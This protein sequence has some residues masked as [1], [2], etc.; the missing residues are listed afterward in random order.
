MQLCFIVSHNCVSYSRFVSQFSE[1]IFGYFSSH[2]AMAP[3]VIL[4][5]RP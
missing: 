2:S 3:G 5:A 4:S 1:L